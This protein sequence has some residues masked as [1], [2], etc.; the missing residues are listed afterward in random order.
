[1]KKFFPLCLAL[2]VIAFIEPVAAQKEYGLPKD[3][4]A[5]DF[6]AKNYLGQPVQLSEYYEEGP[7]VLLFYRGGWCPYCNRQLKNFQDNLNRFEPYNAAVIAVSVDTPENATQT[8]QENVLD[9]EIISNPQADILT[10]YNLTFQVSA[11]LK[12]KYL[13]EYNIDLEK[14]SGRTDGIIA[15]PAIFIIDR[16]GKIVYSYVNEDYQVRKTAQEILDELNK[17]FPQS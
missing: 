4:Q 7:V 17:F 5:P 2:A 6:L 12:E 9:F 11:E 15:V 1:M 3:T 10:S 13:K 14:Y 8:A 16:N